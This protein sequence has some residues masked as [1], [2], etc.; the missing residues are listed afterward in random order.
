[1]FTLSLFW[2]IYNF[3]IQEDKRCELIFITD[4]DLSRTKNLHA[5]NTGFFEHF[6]RI[7][8]VK[9]GNSIAIYNC[10]MGRSVS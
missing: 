1:M 6:V 5:E 7:L 9:L 8:A 2:Q 10:P 4:I 3:Q